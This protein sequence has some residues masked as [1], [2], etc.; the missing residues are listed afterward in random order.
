MLTPEQENALVGGGDCFEHFHSNDRVL[1]TEHKN[2]LIAL[3]K[4]VYLSNGSH[5]VL[6]DTDYVLVDTTLGNATLVLP[7]P[8]LSLSITVIKLVG[9]NSVIVDSPSGTI[10]GS[11]TYTLSSAYQTAKFKAIAGNYYKVA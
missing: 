8:S 11:A 4:S 3:E 2:Y 6:E 7:K 9:D 1:G 5:T 10:N